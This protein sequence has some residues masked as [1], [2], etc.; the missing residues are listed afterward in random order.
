MFVELF[1]LYYLAM[2]LYPLVILLS[3]ISRKLVAHTPPIKPGKVAIIGSGIAGC[4]AA[5]SLKKVCGNVF[6][7]AY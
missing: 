5:W 4:S 1:A 3:M 2:I 7:L 6:D